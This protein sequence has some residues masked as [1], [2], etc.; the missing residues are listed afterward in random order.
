MLN[1]L[2]SAGFEIGQAGVIGGYADVEWEEEATESWIR[3]SPSLW[4]L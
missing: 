1:N 2:S 4:I 3:E